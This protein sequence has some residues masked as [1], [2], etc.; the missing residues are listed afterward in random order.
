MSQSYQNHSKIPWS[1]FTLMAGALLAILLAFLLPASMYYIIV[2]LLAGMLIYGFTYTRMQ[3][4]RMQDRIIRLEMKI[5]FEK[6][7]PEALLQQVDTLT[8]PQII[9]LR[10]AGDSEL[11]EITQQVLDGALT[12][13]E[14][15][16]QAVTDW[17]ADYMRV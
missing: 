3:L 1:I 6:L 16:K 13:P 15:I 17:R 4:L 8:M 2:A 7:L 10:F 14:H 9:A 11:P 12:T 5:R